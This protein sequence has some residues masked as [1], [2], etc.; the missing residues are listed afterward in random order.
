MKTNVHFFYH[1]LLTFSWNEKGLKKVVEK[2]K[3]RI[4]CSVTVF[5]KS[6]RFLDNMENIVERSIDDNMAHAHCMLDN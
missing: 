2:I 4:L 3:T 1:T 5:E 6:C